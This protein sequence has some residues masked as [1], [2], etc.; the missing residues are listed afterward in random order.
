MFFKNLE[1]HM[2]LFLVVLFFISLS[3]CVIGDRRDPLNINMIPKRD[4]ELA[5]KCRMDPYKPE[6]SV[7]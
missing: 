2:R 6:C 1:E 7:N 4:G 5:H 3:G